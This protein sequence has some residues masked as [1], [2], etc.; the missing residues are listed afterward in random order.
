VNVDVPR[1]PVVALSPQWLEMF[2]HTVHHAEKIGIG[3]SIGSGNSKPAG[4][5]TVSRL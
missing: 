4:R 1:G 3:V 2:A 5:S